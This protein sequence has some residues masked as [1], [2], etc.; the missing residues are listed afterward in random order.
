M[1]KN[2]WNVGEAKQQF[3]EVLRRSE[4]EPQLIYRRNRLI[5]AVV[6]VDETTVPAVTRRPSLGERFQ[7]AREL[8]RTE[9]YRLPEVPRRSRRDDFVRTLDAVADGH[10]RSK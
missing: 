9:N 10:K 1:D 4:S 5:A 3:S 7:E 8:F 2:E 6:A